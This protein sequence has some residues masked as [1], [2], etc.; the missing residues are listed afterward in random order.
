MFEFI[1]CSEIQGQHVYKAI[2]ENLI[3]ELKCQRE[4]G[5]SYDPLFVAVI[6]QMDKIQLYGTFLEE[7]L[8]LA[9][10]SFERRLISK[11]LTNLNEQICQIRQFF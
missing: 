11:S 3:V 1:I 9:M 10:L 5:N 7:Y 8:Y 6:E 4:V 2:W